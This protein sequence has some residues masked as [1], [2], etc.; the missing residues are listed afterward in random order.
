MAMSYDSPRR[1]SAATLRHTNLHSRHVAGAMRGEPWCPQTGMGCSVETE[2]YRNG[3]EL[4][5]IA[6]C[7]GV[8]LRPLRSF[9]RRFVIV[10]F[11][12]TPVDA[13]RYVVDT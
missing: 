4:G 10:G 8:P 5:L 6:T 11:R 13:E 3:L 7:F 2:L 12:T 1:F 9:T